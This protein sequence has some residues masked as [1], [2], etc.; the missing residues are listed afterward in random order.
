MKARKSKGPKNERAKLNENLNQSGE[1]PAET[2]GSDLQSLPRSGKA[3]AQVEKP[4]QAPGSGRQVALERG[5][6]H[7][8]QCTKN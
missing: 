1:K 4:R 2:A 5:T 6:H 3:S 8:K 7:R